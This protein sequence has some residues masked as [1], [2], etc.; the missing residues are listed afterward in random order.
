MKILAILLFPLFFVLTGC[1]TTGGAIGDL[2]PA[3]K[4]YKGKVE[5][6]IYYAKDGSF[7]VR[8][9]FEQNTYAYTY[10]EV[11]E[12]YRDIG[13]YV[14]FNTSVCPNEVYRIEIGKKLDKTQ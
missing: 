1:E 2:V 11:K 8:I 14:S 6:G 13:A 12:Q 7:E 3:P 10:M 5:N 4:Y 9:P